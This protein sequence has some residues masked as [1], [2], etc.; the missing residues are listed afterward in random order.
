MNGGAVCVRSTVRVDECRENTTTT[1]AA[2][3]SS[4]IP[5]NAR[6]R[7]TSAPTPRR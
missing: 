1:N 5:A 3:I 6:S 2:A 7:V 4:T